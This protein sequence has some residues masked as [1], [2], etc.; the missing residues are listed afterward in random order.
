MIEAGER[1]VRRIAVGSGIVSVISLAG[2]I[3]G[4]MNSNAGSNADAIFRTVPACANVP[5]DYSSFQYNMRGVLD[6]TKHLDDNDPIAAVMAEIGSKA[7]RDHIQCMRDAKAAIAAARDPRQDVIAGGTAVAGGFFV[8]S[9]LL[10]LTTLP[11][12]LTRARDS[13]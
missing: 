10:A 2:M 6:F 13:A 1:R 3:T 11:H 5:E 9:L 4:V 12:F 8:V 7:F